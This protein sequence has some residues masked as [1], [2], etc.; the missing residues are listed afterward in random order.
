[1]RSGHFVDA[2]T[3]NRI[4]PR[5]ITDKALVDDDF[6]SRTYGSEFGVAMTNIG[7]IDQEVYQAHSA[8]RAANSGQRPTT[9]AQLAPYVKSKIDPVYVDKRMKKIP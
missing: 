3:S 1:M 4:A 5:F 2:S 6:D 8:F 9:A 7:R